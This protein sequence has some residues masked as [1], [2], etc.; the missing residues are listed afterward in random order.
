[1]RQSLA[2]SFQTTLFCCV[3]ATENC[4]SLIAISL[5]K[6]KSIEKQKPAPSFE[7]EFLEFDFK[8]K[9]EIVEIENDFA[10]NVITLFLKFNRNT[11]KA[12][13]NGYWEENEGFYLQGLSL[14]IERQGETP[15][16]GFLL[17]TLWAMFGLSSQ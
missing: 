6:L 15:T 17:K 1:M 7:V 13:L 5:R 10:S 9:L 12:I 11:I 14:G 16:S 4:Y 8:F 3:H 2:V